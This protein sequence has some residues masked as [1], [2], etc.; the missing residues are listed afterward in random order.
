[1]SDRASNAR[2]GSVT[3]A[4]LLGSVQWMPPEQGVQGRAPIHQQLSFDDLHDIADLRASDE[5]NADAVIREILAVPSA[6]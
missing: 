2:G 5:A 4:G 1:M 3:P 6:R